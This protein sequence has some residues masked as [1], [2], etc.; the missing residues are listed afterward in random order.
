VSSNPANVLSPSDLVG[1]S[2]VTSNG[3]ETT[4]IEDDVSD[5]IEQAHYEDVSQ[6][7]EVYHHAASIAFNTPNFG[8]AFHAYHQLA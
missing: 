1:P 6:R 2:P 3:T 8:I 4:E 5:E 7:S